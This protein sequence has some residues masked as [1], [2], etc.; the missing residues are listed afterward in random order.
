MN[1]YEEM[2]KEAYEDIIDSFEKEA[3]TLKGPHKMNSVDK[4]LYDTFKANQADAIKLKGNYDDFYRR[5]LSSNPAEARAARIALPNVTKEIKDVNNR[6][7]DNITTANTNGFAER[8]PM[9][10]KKYTTNAS[11]DKLKNPVSRKASSSLEVLKPAADT[12]IG[13][14]FNDPKPTLP[15]PLTNTANNV[16]VKPNMGVS[17]KALGIGGA[18]IAGAAALGYGIHKHNQKKKEEQDRQRAT[19]INIIR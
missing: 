11:I 16:P 2:V 12:Q 7:W 3:R 19:N 5:S 6:L 17:G 4:N 1:Y 13:I 18:A 14:K 10:G 9:I 15:A 8:N